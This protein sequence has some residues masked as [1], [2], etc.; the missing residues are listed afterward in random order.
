MISAIYVRKSTDQATN[1]LPIGSLTIENTI[2]TMR[3][4]PAA[5]RVAGVVNANSTS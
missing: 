1:P 3:L 2:G 5:A 4:T